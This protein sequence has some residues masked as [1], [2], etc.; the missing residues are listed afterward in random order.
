[1]PN[2]NPSKL[3]SLKMPDYSG[4]WW[5][6]RKSDT[7]T[8][9]VGKWTPVGVFDVAGHSLW[10][11]TPSIRFESLP[12]VAPLYNGFTM[13]TKFYFAPY[14]LY[15]PQ[16]RKNHH[17]NWGTI[18]G[19]KLPRFVYEN[20]YQQGVDEQTGRLSLAGSLLERLKMGYGEMTTFQSFHNKVYSIPVATSTSV[21]YSMS[22]STNCVPFLA[23]LDAWLYGEYNPQDK[24]IPVDRDVWSLGGSV[25]SSSGNFGRLYGRSWISYD[26]LKQ[27]IPAF[28][29]G[30]A[31]AFTGSTAEL[32]YKN[33]SQ[34]N[35]TFGRS[36]IQILPGWDLF[37][38]AKG[39]ADSGTSSALNY[40]QIGANWSNLRNSVSSVGLLPVTYK[41]DY[42]TAWYSEEAINQ[43]SNYA[44]SNGNLLQ[45]RR[46]NRDFMVN[47]LSLVSGN[48]YV[49]YLQYVFD[50]DLEL[51]DHPI[52]V[53][54]DEIDFGA[55]DVVANAQTGDGNTGVLGA[56]ASKA[57][58][59]NST[60]KPISFKSQEPGIVLVCSA[61]VPNVVCWQGTPRMMFDRAIEDLW[62]PQYSSMGFM[63]TFRGEYFNPWF[64]SDVD[65]WT[66][67]LN[68][69]DEATG[70]LQFV[71][72]M[73]MNKTAITKVPLGWNYMAT[74]D[75]ISGGMMTE[76]YKSWTLR[77]YMD[78]SSSYQHTGT[79]LEPRVTEYYENMITTTML[80]SMKSTYVDSFLYNDS[81][82][83]NN[84]AECENF[85]I[86]YSFDMSIYQP[87]SHQ[88]ITKYM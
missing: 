88:L 41:G 74:Y 76:Q 87:I 29:Y 40:N 8:L 15:I 48:R 37:S 19:L 10:K 20:T 49:D 23:Y 55:I 17:L 47:L 65:G 67:G 85:V 54:Y 51:K 75:T 24:N 9:R 39:V 27:I 56:S 7:T 18:P 50:T 38:R 12:M 81:F 26:N 46:K 11:C 25:A 34:N 71:S 31:L 13:R 70:V 61:I 52:M 36:G 21:N 22:L 66:S 2:N 5:K 44:V 69:K 35:F 86:K 63:D 64:C 6:M 80:D 4:S 57:R 30:D 77:R 3:A 68:I 78:N 32:G 83:N 82:A 72:P 62:H 16:L 33:T 14:R 84:R 1:M 79:L 28:A 53:G 60:V 42:L 43:L 45:L 59:Y 73:A 58:E